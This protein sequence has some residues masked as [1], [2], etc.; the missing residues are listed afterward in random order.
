MKIIKTWFRTEIEFTPEE[1]E[2]LWYQVDPS[3]TAGLFQWFLDNYGLDLF[4]K[5]K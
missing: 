3:V 2:Q 4:P 5:E 1:L